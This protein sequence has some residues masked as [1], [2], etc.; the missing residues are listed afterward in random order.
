MIIYR[1]NLSNGL[2]IRKFSRYI[3]ADSSG[4]HVS[5]NDDPSRLEG[6]LDSSWADEGNLTQID[7]TNAISTLSTHVICGLIKPDITGTWQFRLRSDDAGYLWIGT[8]SKPLE[9]NLNKSDALC[10]NGGGHSAQNVDNSITLTA[11]QLYSFKALVG[12][13]GGGD[14]FVVDF[15]GPTGSNWTSA[16]SN[17]G[18]DGTGFYFH[19]P[20]APNGYNLNS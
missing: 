12:D 7:R 9:W 16:L 2:Y 14:A 13:R 17:I 15:R 5:T 20:Y 11:G 6:Y 19:N 4:N 10:D 8:N 3:N 1:K 18:R